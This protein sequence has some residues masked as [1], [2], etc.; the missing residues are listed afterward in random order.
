MFILIIIYTF[1]N[2]LF[3]NTV[4]WVAIVKYKKIQKCPSNSKFAIKRKTNRAKRI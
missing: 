2:T 4:E 1:G 3:K